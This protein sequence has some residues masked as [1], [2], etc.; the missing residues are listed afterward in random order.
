MHTSGCATIIK[1]AP[2]PY[3]SLIKTRRTP[4]IQ[5]DV[6]DIASPILLPSIPLA[7]YGVVRNCHTFA[8]KRVRVRKR[9]TYLKFFS[10]AAPFEDFAIDLQGELVET[11]QGNKHLLV[12]TDRFKKLVKIVP[13]R[14][15]RTQDS[16]EPSFDIGYLFMEHHS[17]SSWTTVHNLQQSFCLRPTMYLASKNCSPQRITRKPM[18]KRKGTTA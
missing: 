4:W 14:K 18:V 9:S 12:I 5:A 15:I 16:L 2:A 7:V 11:T 10:A 3:G 6:Q 1:A 13:L 8:K 17:P